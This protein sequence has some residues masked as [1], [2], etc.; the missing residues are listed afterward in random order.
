[1]PRAARVVTL[2][3][4]LAWSADEVHASLGE[5]V[6][7]EQAAA[8]PLWEPLP[9][10]PDRPTIRMP[11]GRQ[12][13]PQQAAVETAADELF[14][15]GAAGSGKTDLGLG[16]AITKHRNSIIFRQEFTQLRGPEG[17]IA[18]SQEIIGI[19][20]DYNAGTHVWHDLPGHRALEFGGVRTEK[21][22]EKWRGRPHDLKVFDEVAEFPELLYRF[23]C[24]WLRTTV[25]GQRCRVVCSGNPPSTAEGEWVIR[26]W[27]PWLDPLHSDPAAP[28]ELRW[29]ASVDG[30]D[31]AVPSTPGQRPPPVRDAEGRLVYPRS[32]TFIPA[33]VEDNPHYM[34]TGYD[35]QLDALPEP[36]RSQ[37]RYGNF[38]IGLVADAFQIIQTEWVVA[39]QARWTPTPPCALECVG[40]D[41]SWGGAD[42]FVVAKRHGKW[43]ATLEKTAGV[44][45]HDGV[46]GAAIIY[47]SVGGNKDIPIQ[48]DTGGNLSTYDQAKLQ[49]GLNAIGLNGSRPAVKMVNGSEVPITD[50]TGLMTFANKRAWWHWRMH[51][52]LNPVFGHNIALPPDP[53]LR[54]DLCAPRY[55][56]MDRRGIQ[57][58]K[59][60]EI[61]AR[62]GRS[63]DCGEAVIYACVDEHTVPPKRK[64]KLVAW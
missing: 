44:D 3:E 37:L 5:P 24:G 57:V 33:R 16:L 56:V 34:R 61:K 55:K 19:R 60:E 59:K 21:D 12:L 28:A 62:L 30:K 2:S 31:V 45:A 32:R 54:A 50:R 4:L 10:E 58:E 42:Q 35:R 26:Y 11:D 6:A 8:P 46:R 47:K 49:L 18:R 63:P 13:S 36:M 64:R 40:A 15:G 39:A 51:E 23:L 20:G 7:A 38:Q 53:Q 9:P 25:I 41:I 52:L 27:A 29:Y 48:I 17:V 1:M 43:I 22:R 14:Y